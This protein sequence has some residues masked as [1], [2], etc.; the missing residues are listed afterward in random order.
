MLFVMVQLMCLIWQIVKMFLVANF[1]I[2]HKIDAHASIYINVEYRT[3]L[4]TTTFEWP[5]MEE[6]VFKQTYYMKVYPEVS[7]FTARTKNSK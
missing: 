1:M 2:C 5:I 6:C 4:F 3:I 7:D